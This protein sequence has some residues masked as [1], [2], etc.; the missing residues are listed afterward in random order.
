MKKHFIISISIFLVIICIS[1]ESLVNQSNN[2]TDSAIDL[3]SLD[4]NLRR[5]N[6]LLD[7]RT[8]TLIESLKETVK[9]KVMYEALAIHAAKTTELANDFLLYIETLRNRL[10]EEAGGVYI[11]SEVND[12][13]LI[14]KPKNPN[15]TKIVNHIFISDNNAE[16]NIFNDR[17]K[18]LRSKYLDFVGTLWDNGGIKGTIFADQSK[19]NQALYQLEQDILLIDADKLYSKKDKDPNWA[20]L[21]FKDKSVAMIYLLLRKYENEVKMSTH[22]V[23]DF[24]ASQMGKLEFSYDRF[25][26][27]TKTQKPAI[28]LGEVYEA[29]IALGVYTSQAQFAVSV[30][31]SSLKTK[32]GKALYQVKPSSEGQQKYTV[33]I[34]I[35]NPLTG[36]TETITKDF[37]Y[38]VIP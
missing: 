30:N 24:I 38:E 32:D 5:N 4:E 8:E 3:Y 13:V 7:N 29:E 37:Y 12:L 25:D 18:E 35:Q 27:T 20:Q 19:K 17:V 23:V 36:E 34:S 14:N 28:R 15:D 11:Q 31:G 33:K 10:I 1:C 21:A 6:L 9:T 2:S 26:I 22:A 16:A